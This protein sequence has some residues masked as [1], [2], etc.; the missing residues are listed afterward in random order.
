MQTGQLAYE[1][2]YE[3]INDN[4][5][6]LTHL[7]Y[8]HE[9]TLGRNSMSWGESRPKV[10]PIDRG[11]RI[12]R[13]VVNHPRPNYLGP[14]PRSLSDMWAS[15]DYKVPGVF[16]L[17][18][19]SYPPGMSAGCGMSAPTAEPDWVSSTSQAVTPVTE[20]QTIYYYSS[21]LSRKFATQ[22][23]SRQQMAVIETAFAEDRAMI[24]A[25]QCVLDRTQERRMMILSTDGALNQFRRLMAGLIE[26]EQ[27]SMAQPAER[28]FA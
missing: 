8:V 9:K 17:A 20:H 11:L 21:C 14:P 6:D 15:Y 13:W 18:T 3:L 16:L 2:N 25:Q 27:V 4:L 10:T 23:H 26:A 24:E 22:E 19:K 5:L 1:A 28:R 12:A 7:S